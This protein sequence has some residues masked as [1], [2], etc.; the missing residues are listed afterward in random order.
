MS[1]DLAARLVELARRVARLERAEQP[2]YLIATAT[3]DPASIANAGYAST[4]VTCTGAAAGDPVEVGFSSLP[5]AAWRINAHAYANGVYVIIQNLTGG[6]I[7]LGSG[8]VKV[9]VRK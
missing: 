7:D 2:K 9:V 6:P 4:T 8:T 3:W 5:N 1:V